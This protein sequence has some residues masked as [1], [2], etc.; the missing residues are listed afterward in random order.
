MECDEKYRYYIANPNELA[1]HSIESWLLST[2]TV[3]V[4]LADSTTVKNRIVLEDNIKSFGSY[5][6]K[7]K[8]GYEISGTV[9]VV[10]TEDK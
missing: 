9:N 1:D 2:M 10:V 6:V 4:A 5:D 8:L 7:C 3:S